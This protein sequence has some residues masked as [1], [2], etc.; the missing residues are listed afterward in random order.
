MADRST[1]DHF[2]EVFCPARVGPIMRERG[3]RSSRS[4]DIKSGWVLDQDNICRQ[5]FVDLMSLRPFF[6]LLC[7]PCTMFSTMMFS[8]WGKMSG[9][10]KYADLKLAVNH[11]DFAML[12]AKFQRDTGSYYVF[13]HPEGAQ[14]WKRHTVGGSIRRFRKLHVTHCPHVCCALSV[15]CKAMDVTHGR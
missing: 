6:V 7:P 15:S 12:V 5:V 2:W 10:Q 14:S 9:D 11:L 4:L 13:E 1:Q 8:N 3:F